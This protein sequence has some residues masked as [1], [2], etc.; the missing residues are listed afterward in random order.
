[1]GEKNRYLIYGLKVE[2]EISIPQAYFIEENE[3]AFTADVRIVLGEI[4]REFREAAEK[5]YGSWIDGVRAAW[6]NTEGAAQYFIEEGKTIIV[7]PY[8]NAKEMLVTS[9]IL[10][11]GMSLILL[12]RNEPVLHGSVVEKAGNA[13]LICGN[14]GAGKSTVTLELLDDK[15]IMLMADD[16]VRLTREGNTVYCHPTYPQQKVCR[17]LAC[18]KNLDFEELI[19]IDEG[20]DKYAIK[21]KD[22]YCNTKKPLKAIFVLEKDSNETKVKYERLCGLDYVYCI[23]NNLYLSENYKKD[24]GIPPEFMRL[25]NTMYNQANIYKVIRPENGNTVK[26]VTEMIRF[27]QSC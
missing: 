13:Y 24:V 15:E 25:I 5:G 6:F 23:I 3:E 8:P 4:P 27:L 12:Q 22:R 2:S 26:E 19:Y 11:A 18:Q 20:R 14:S 9:M 7:K 1:M 10:S 21:R 17:N 16:T